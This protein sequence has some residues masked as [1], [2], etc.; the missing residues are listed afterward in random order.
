MFFD[1]RTYH[2]QA[3]LQV[4]N[5]AQVHEND[6]YVPAGVDNRE[7]PDQPPLVVWVVVSLPHDSQ[8]RIRRDALLG[9]V[10]LRR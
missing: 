5:M 1:V 6:G 9:W 10:R 8:V 4:W 7:V 2:F 3:S